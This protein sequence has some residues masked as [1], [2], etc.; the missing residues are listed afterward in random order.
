MMLQPSVQQFV[1]VDY[2]HIFH[3]SVPGIHF[4]FCSVLASTTELLG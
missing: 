2:L 1:M 4:P 3:N